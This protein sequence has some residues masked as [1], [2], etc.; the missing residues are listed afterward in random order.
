MMKRLASLRS[1]APHHRDLV[2]QQRVK[3][4]GDGEIIGGAERAA[5]KSVEL[6]TRDAVDRLRHVETAAQQLDLRRLAAARGRSARKA[7]SS[8]AS[9]FGPRGV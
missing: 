3:A 1:L 7:A 2:D 5:T 8:A 9:A 6:E 4:L